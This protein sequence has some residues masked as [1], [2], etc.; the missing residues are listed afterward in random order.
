MPSFQSGA[1]RPVKIL[2]PI[3]KKL[4]AAMRNQ[5]PETASSKLKYVDR[6]EIAETFADG[7]ETVIFD[8]MSVRM[9]FVVNRFEQALPDTA[10]MGRKVTALRLVLPIAGAVNLTAQLERLLA[11]LKDQGVLN[12]LTLVQSAND[13]N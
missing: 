12:E 1:L 13:V 5:P 8:G 6:P 10:P 7:L 2:L 9:E 3:V 11:A 4:G